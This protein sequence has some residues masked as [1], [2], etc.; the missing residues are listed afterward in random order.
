MSLQRFTAFLAIFIISA[1]ALFSDENASSSGIFVEDKSVQGFEF[2]EAYSTY[3]ELLE[4]DRKSAIEKEKTKITVKS[5]VPNAEVFLN[6]NFEGHTNLTV[7]D[8]PAGRY[9]LRVK[10][11]RL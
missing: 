10:K 8:L 7:N 5:N 2:D 3:P 1:G 11:N 6:G 4:S 9:N